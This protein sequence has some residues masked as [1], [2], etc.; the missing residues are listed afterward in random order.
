V[1][2][3]NGSFSIKKVLP[4]FFPDDPKL[5]YHNLPGSVHHDGEAM[6]IFP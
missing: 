5:D 2:A 4:A 1:P 6:N 3:M